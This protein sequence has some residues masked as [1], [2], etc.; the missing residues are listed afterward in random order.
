MGIQTKKGKLVIL[1]APSGSGKTT[2]V[3]FLLSQIPDLAF[4]V[5]AT[6]R[7]A[8]GGEKDGKDYFFLSVS[9]FRKKITEGAFV[10]WEEVYE[11]QF[12]GSLNAE[13]ERLRDEG[14]TVAF[15]IDVKGGLNIK[16]KYGK[17]ALAV[18][19]KPPSVS[20]LEQRLRTRSTEDE[21]SIRKRIERATYE[22]SFEKEFD[23]VV[24][25]DH[26]EKAQQESLN[27]IRT[28]LQKN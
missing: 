10:E 7:P 11:N 28:F 24:I 22:L 21:A 16:K 15:D 23:V 18:F 4:S 6:S 9:D 20:V 12:Y 3:H 17:D 27:I 14:K 2:L 26:L 5:S 13:V 19:V 8:R 25:N 1:S